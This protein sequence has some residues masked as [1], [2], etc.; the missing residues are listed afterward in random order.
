MSLKFV[1][2]PNPVSLFSVICVNVINEVIQCSNFGFT[3]GM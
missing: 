2:V 1:W 3:N